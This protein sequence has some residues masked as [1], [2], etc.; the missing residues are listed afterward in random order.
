MVLRY[1]KP[2]SGPQNGFPVRKMF[3]WL[4]KWFYGPQNGFIIIIRELGV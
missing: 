3:L 4:A 1:E 2:F